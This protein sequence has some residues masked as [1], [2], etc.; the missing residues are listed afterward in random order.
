MLV[1]QE[2][3]MVLKIYWWFYL[4]ALIVSFCVHTYKHGE[5]MGNYNVLAGMIKVLIYLPWL[6][7][8]YP[9]IMH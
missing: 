1:K 6:I 4:V 2:E 5:T 3:R 9:L 8:L 7:L